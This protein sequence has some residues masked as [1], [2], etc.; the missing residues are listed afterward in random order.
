VL[1]T[2]CLRWRSDDAGSVAVVTCLSLPVLIGC[3]ALAVDASV[4]ASQ[5]NAA[6]GAA[7]FAALA[8]AVAA[9]S[10]N[11]TTRIRTEASAITS[12]NGFTNGQNGVIVTVNNP[13][14]AGAHAS[15]SS[16]WEVVVAQAQKLYFGGGILSN[17]P[18]V[19]VRAVAT[20]G[21]SPACVLALN[22]SASGA[23]SM[24]GSAIVGAK[25]CAVVANSTSTTDVKLSGSSCLTATQLTM[26]GNY[27]SSSS[28]PLKV[29]TIKA[30]A[31]AIADPYAGLTI[32]AFSG[33]AKTSYSLSGSSVATIDPGVYCNGITAS[34]SSKLTMNP[35][36]YTINSGSLNISGSSTLVAS[37]GVSIILTSTTSN[38]GTVSFSGS[39]TVT[40]TAPTT[41]AMAGIAIYVDRA[42]PTKSN[43]FSGSSGQNIFGVIYTPTQSATYSGSAS[44]SAPCLKLVADTITFSGSA[45]FGVN[46]GSGVVAGFQS[47]APSLVE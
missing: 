15:D 9:T 20:P 41:G 10:G 6:Q 42:A 14:L 2:R 18:T 19:T 25:N 29:G 4:W 38:F 5:K 36:I 44:A 21:T 7:D 17:A 45:G 13:P 31:S 35:G 33:C 43:S 28:C 23:I 1:L 27:T 39:T 8:A 30:N 26:G 24:S 40:L 22:P 32:P 47:G 11:S 3:A 12:L 37:S 34:A 16:A 46:C